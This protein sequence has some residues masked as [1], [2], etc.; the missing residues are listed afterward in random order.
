[1]ARIIPSLTRQDV[2][3]DCLINNAAVFEKDDLATLTPASWQGHMQTNLFAPLLLIRDFA[4][5]YKGSA[6]NII[7]IT[8]GLAGW[9]VS[10]TFFSYAMSKLALTDATRMLVR[11]LAPAIRINAIAPGATL[12]GEHDKKDAFTKL[13]EVIPL[14]RVS[15]PEEICAAVHYILS[16]PSLSG[17]ILS[18]A[19][20]IETPYQ[21]SV[22]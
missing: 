8:D 10:P 9:S 11:E 21:F 1:V 3:L 12:E 19:G 7:N 22:N 4:K 13:R 17:Q 20:G 18:L 5:Q 6:G 2:H 14:A 15:A 16:A